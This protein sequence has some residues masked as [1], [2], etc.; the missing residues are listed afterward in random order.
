M[1]EAELRIGTFGDT[2]LDAAH[3]SGGIERH[4]GPRHEA[5]EKEA[6]CRESLVSRCS[7][8]PDNRG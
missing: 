2:V 4:R 5:V 7:Q 8:S 6:Q 1:L 3:G